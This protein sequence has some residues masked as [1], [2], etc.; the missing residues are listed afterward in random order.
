MMIKYLIDENLSSQVALRLREELCLDMVHVRERGL[1]GEPD[2]VVFRAAYDED[3][4]LVTANVRDFQALARSAELHAGVVLLLE[5]GLRLPAQMDV[6]RRAVQ[7]IAEEAAAGR[8]MINRSL[9][10]SVG[11]HRFGELP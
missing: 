11:E 1:L 10:I 6:M 5:G 4:I 8:D 9:E 2:P 7:L 3:R